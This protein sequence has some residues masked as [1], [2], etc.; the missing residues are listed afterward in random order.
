MKLFFGSFGFS[1]CPEK[2][3]FFARLDSLFAHFPIGFADYSFAAVTRFGNCVLAGLWA[4][5]LAGV[6]R[7]IGDVA[8]GFATNSFGFLL[9]AGPQP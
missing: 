5:T 3:L 1:F 2:A 8:T 6:G 7:G 9:I 4:F